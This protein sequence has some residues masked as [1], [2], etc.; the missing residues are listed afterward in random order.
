MNYVK[1]YGY[2]NTPRTGVVGWFDTGNDPYQWEIRLNGAALGSMTSLNEWK[3]TEQWWL[4]VLKLLKA[5]TEFIRTGEFA[6]S[7]V[8]HLDLGRTL[9]RLGVD[10]CRFPPLELTPWV[11]DVF[12]SGKKTHR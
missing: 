5:D 10:C 7:S 8:V 9:N 2:N 3:T 4:E 6:N 12:L 1:V 11:R